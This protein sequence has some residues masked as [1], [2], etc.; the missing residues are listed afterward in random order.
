RAPPMRVWETQPAAT[1]VRLS[2]EA[3]A[4]S[5]AQEQDGRTDWPIALVSLTLHPWMRWQAREAPCGTG[6]PEPRTLPVRR[7]RPTPKEHVAALRR[8]V[9]AGRGSPGTSRG[10]APAPPLPH[11]GAASSC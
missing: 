1:D 3:P 9:A 2:D 4:S 6:S 7:P 10:P 5:D 8:R 11:A